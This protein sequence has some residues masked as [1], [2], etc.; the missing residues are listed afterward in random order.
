VLASAGTAKPRFD[1][2]KF[3]DS[4]L[5]IPISYFWLLPLGVLIGAFGTSIGAGGGFLL[6]RSC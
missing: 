6:V 3:Q 4:M 2:G 5:D 1:S